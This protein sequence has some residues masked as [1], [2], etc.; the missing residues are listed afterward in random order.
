MSGTGRIT[1]ALLHADLRVEGLDYSRGLLDRLRGKLQTR[2]LVTELYEAN[3]CDFSTGKQYGLIY[4]GFNSI[5]EV[6][7]DDDK[8]KLFARVRMHLLPNGEF[9]LTA[10]N[11]A[12]RAMAFDGCERP[13]LGEQIKLAGGKVLEATGRYNLDPISKVV[14]GEQRFV[15]SHEGRETRRVVQNVRFHLIE[16]LQLEQLLNASGFTVTQRFGDYT[17]SAFDHET[18]PFFIVGCCATSSS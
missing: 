15:V 5:A 4:I 2:G 9:W 12:I 10:H 11:P 13:L 14:T 3:A 6:V 18:S 8:R 17:G 1:L 7:V 16:P